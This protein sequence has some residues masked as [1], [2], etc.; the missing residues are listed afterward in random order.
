MLLHLVWTLEPQLKH[1]ISG[2]LF[3]KVLQQT[4]HERD[5]YAAVESK[6]SREN[7]S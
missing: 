2:L 5:M 6:F 3:D 1:G 4:E 7:L